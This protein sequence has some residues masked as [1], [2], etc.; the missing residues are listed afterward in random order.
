M[1]PPSAPKDPVHPLAQDVS[2]YE[3]LVGA[4]SEPGETILDPCCGTG[5]T[6]L[7]A[8]R[9]GRDSIGLDNDAGMVALARRRLGLP[10]G[11]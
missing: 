4:L 6:L 5:T 11:G 2:V 7:A 10:P 3:T 8:R 9:L 1:L